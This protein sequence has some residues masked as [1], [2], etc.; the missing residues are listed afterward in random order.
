MEL[1]VGAACDRPAT[2]STEIEITP[3]MIAAGRLQ[4]A[5]V[6]NEFISDYGVYIWHE[7]LTSVYLAMYEA[8]PRSPRK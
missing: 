7:V 1:D 3:A 4:I 2:E 8:R 6:W 5:K